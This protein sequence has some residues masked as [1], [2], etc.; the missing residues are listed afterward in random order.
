MEK[1]GGTKMDKGDI[2]TVNING[3][4]VMVCIVDHYTE[5][6]S[7]QEMVVLALISQDNV[8]QIPAQDLEPLFSDGKRLN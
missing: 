4:Q 3:S 8:F 7:G 1:S 5:E 6:V 2:F